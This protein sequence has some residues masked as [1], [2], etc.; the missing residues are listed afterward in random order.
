MPA[1][2]PKQKVRAVQR[3][4]KD[5]ATIVLKGDT[6]DDAKNASIQYVKENG[7]VMVSP[8][9]DQLIIEGQGTVGL[10]IIEQLGDIQP[11]ISSC[12]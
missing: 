1:T 7:S 4:G 2:T 5:W 3:L 10:E 6:Y 11:D 8:F 12:Q 9:D